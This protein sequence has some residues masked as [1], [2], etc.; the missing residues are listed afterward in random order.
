MR[1]GILQE[2]RNVLDPVSPVPT[3]TDPV[4]L[5]RTLITPPPYTA[6]PTPLE[7]PLQNVLTSFHLLCIHLAS[8]DLFHDPLLT[9]LWLMY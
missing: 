1:A 3:A 5:Q 8:L 6:H 4:E 7:G 2:V 9:H